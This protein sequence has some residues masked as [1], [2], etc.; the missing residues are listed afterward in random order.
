MAATRT[1]PV[2]KPKAE[3]KEFEFVPETELGRQLWEARKKIQQSGIPMFH[4]WEELEAEI[5]ERKGGY[6]G[7]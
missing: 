7:N 5:A 3:P 2:A 4:T 6:R 1:K